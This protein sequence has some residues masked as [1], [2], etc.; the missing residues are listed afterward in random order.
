MLI[1]LIRRLGFII[2]IRFYKR[3]REKKIIIKNNKYNHIKKNNIN[4][5]G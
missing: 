5:K 4:N 3:E 2:L 1:V